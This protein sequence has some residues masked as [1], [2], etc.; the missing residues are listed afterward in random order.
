MFEMSNKDYQ[1]FTGILKLKQKTLLR[2]VEKFLSNY[3][4]KENLIIKDSFIMAKGTIPI[5][6]IAHLDTVFEVQP[7]LI[8]YDQKQHLMWSPQGLGADDRAG[9]FSI[10]KIITKGYLPSVCFTT[11]EEI[12]GLGASDVITYFP[13]PITNLKY[14]IQLD[15]QGEN[16]CVFYQCDNKDFREYVETYGFITAPGSYTDI[17]FICPKWGI[18]GVNL[19]V[20]YFGEHSTREML[21]TYYMY[22]TIQKVCKMLDDAKNI[23]TSFKYIKRIT[24]SIF[25]PNVPINWDDDN[26]S[27]Y[28]KYYHECIKCK[29]K[30]PEQDTFKISTVDNSIKYICIDCINDK[31]IG[32][33]YYCG[34]PFELIREG[35]EKICPS[36]K[37]RGVTLSGYGL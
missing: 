11:D 8:L 22:L 16:D 25:Y 31:H 1:T 29:K 30:V 19:S 14:I 2:F 32:W 5:M 10:I 33:C 18:A 37:A 15:R 23:K 21:S 6:L 28:G 12:G 7:S 24:N 9:V 36:C 34:E 17:S 4:P 35:E 3:Y 26:D 13:N 27:F 20:G